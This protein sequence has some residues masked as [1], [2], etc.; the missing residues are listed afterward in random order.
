MRST[1]SSAWS[2][3]PAKHQRKPDPADRRAKLVCPT[4]R[5]WLKR[6][7]D[8]IMAAIHERDARRLGRDIFTLLRT[9][10]ID[11]TEHER[12][13]RLDAAGAWRRRVRGPR[14]PCPRPAPISPG[15]CRAICDG[16]PQRDRSACFGSGWR[17]SSPSRPRS[18]SFRHS[19]MRSDSQG[20]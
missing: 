2:T 18:L 5:G 4:E 11:L 6:A 3:A 7:A 20:A 12:R 15:T 16:S 13:E 9:T 1:W 19:V 17:S 8:E 10:L 14:D